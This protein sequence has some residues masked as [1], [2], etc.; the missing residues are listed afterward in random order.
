MKSKFAI[1]FLVFL[2]LIA[3]AP[4]N[5]FSATNHVVISEVQI[6]GTTSADEFV[7]LYNPT[8]SSVSLNGWTIYRKTAS[9]GA[10]EQLM[11][12]LSGSIPAHGFYLI[13]NAS[14]DDSVSPEIT[15]S[16]QN[17]ADDNSVILKDGANIVVDLVGFG[18]S[19]T[20]EGA[21]VQAPVVNRSIERK[22]SSASTALSMAI[23]GTDEFL[24]NGEDTENNSAD[25]VRHMS[26]AVSNPQNTGSSLEPAIT[27]T[28]TPIVTPSP[29]PSTSP[30]GSPTP[31]PTSTP[32]ATV[33]PEP[34]QTPEPTATASPS[35]SPTP[36]PSITPKPDIEKF[37]F[38]CAVSFKE[39]RG[40]FF[41]IKLPRL[42]CSRV[43]LH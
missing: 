32:D 16:D 34:S 6:A 36:K 39:I 8:G 17:I 42:T 19:A 40:R 33:T 21:T 24:G 37:R 13:A 3:S 12:S 23:G 31:E 43:W 26:P 15:Y 25:F 10:V 4:Y 41:V 27:E 5:I 18:D 38:V 20:Y 29:S 2:I 11:A 28:P 35:F 14:Y 7:E 30:T 9:A 22:A 1:V